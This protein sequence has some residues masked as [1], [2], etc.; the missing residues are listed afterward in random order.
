[1]L[2]KQTYDYFSDIDTSYWKK[3]ASLITKRKILARINGLLG[4]LLDFNKNTI[5]NMQ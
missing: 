4:V 5:K 1:M 3:M 2:C